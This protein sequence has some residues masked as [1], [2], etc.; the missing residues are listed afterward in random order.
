MTQTRKKTV[1]RCPACGKKVVWSEE[2]PWRPFCSQRCRTMDLGDW[3]A[4]R[5]RV[6]GEPAPPDDPESMN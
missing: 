1:V 3:L 4:E 6:P 5:H 2:S